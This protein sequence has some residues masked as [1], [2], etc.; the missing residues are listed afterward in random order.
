[1]SQC[2]SCSPTQAP[3]DLNK[4]CPSSWKLICLVYLDCQLKPQIYH[5]VMRKGALQPR[6]M[7]PW[8]SG[9]KTL[10]SCEGIMDQRL[11]NLVD[12]VEICDPIS[13]WLFQ[14]SL[15]Y[16]AGR[17]SQH[18][19]VKCLFFPRYLNHHVNVHG[20]LPDGLPVFIHQS[21]FL[22]SLLILSSPSQLLLP[23][24]SL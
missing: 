12:R 5:Q 13:F 20:L 2:L 7:H 14:W 22:T 18:V 10:F 19:P 6:L 24:R 23:F 17:T 9:T 11:K 1:M 4:L 16:G 3:M 15:S 21:Y 8:N